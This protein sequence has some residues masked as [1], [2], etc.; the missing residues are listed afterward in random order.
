MQN[1][2]LYNYRTCKCAPDHTPLCNLPTR[3]GPKLENEATFCYFFLSDLRLI[4]TTATPTTGYD[5]QVSMS[6][7]DAAAAPLRLTTSTA[8]SN[9]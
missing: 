5:Y 3:G 7:P 2:V 4:S 1:V 8:T 6:L 9:L